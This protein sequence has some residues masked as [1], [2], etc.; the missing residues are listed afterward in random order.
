MTVATSPDFAT[1]WESFTRA[2]RARAL[3]LDRPA[4]RHGLTLAQ[5]QLLEPLRAAEE[6]RSRS[7][8]RPPASPR[9]PPRACSTGWCARGGRAH[10]LRQRTAA[11]S[12][13]R[14]PLRAAPPSRTARTGRR[15]A[16]ARARQPHRRGAGA[17]RRAAAAGSPRRSTR[18]EAAPATSSPPADPVRLRRRAARHVA[19]RPQ[20]DDRRHRAA[21]IVADLGGVEHYSWVFT[22]YMLASTVTMPVYGRLSDIYGRRRFFVTGIV[23]FMIGGIVGATSRLDDAA[24]S[25]RAASRASAPAR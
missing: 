12:S 9:R 25:S 10:A 19:R 14:S 3:A 1:A 2:T 15:G 17:G 23:V 16:G 20:P 24:R 11:S 5:F 21:H 18:C 7:S 13:S 22:A 8:P 6:R 4:G